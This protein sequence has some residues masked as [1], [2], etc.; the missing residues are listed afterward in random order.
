MNI[1]NKP[2]IKNI[3]NNIARVK[4]TGFIS[5]FEFDIFFVQN[6]TNNDI[7]N[8]GVN[9]INSIKVKKISTIIIFSILLPLQ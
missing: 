3:K 9:I 7:K 8:I 6:F 2:P 1:K 4:L 5:Y